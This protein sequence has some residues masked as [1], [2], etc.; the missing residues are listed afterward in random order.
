MITV[1]IPNIPKKTMDKKRIVVVQPAIGWLV[2]YM[3]RD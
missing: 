1:K 3:N 2:R